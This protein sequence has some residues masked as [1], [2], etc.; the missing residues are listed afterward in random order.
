MTKMLQAVLIEKLARAIRDL[1]ENINDT[2][3]TGLIV[4]VDIEISKQ[5]RP[6][7]SAR[8]NSK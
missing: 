8:V 3:D 6:Q 4:S 2:I 1:N 7:V 5:G